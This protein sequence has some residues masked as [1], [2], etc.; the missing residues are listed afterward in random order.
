MNSTTFGK[1]RDVLLTSCDNK[2]LYQHQRVQKCKK[3]L[4]LLHNI[5]ADSTKHCGECDYLGLV[6][7]RLNF[8]ENPTDYRE[9]EAGGIDLYAVSLQTL[10]LVVP[11]PLPVCVCERELSGSGQTGASG[12]KAALA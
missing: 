3:K 1:E 11:V 6:L 2:N 7:H 4:S 12:H 10:L 8:F 5:K 9:G